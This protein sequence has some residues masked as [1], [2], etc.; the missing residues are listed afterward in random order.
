MKEATAKDV[1]DLISYEG[2]IVGKT[3]LQKIAALLEISGLGAGFSFSYHYYGPYSEDFASAVDRAALLGLIRED[4]RRANWGGRYSVF[5]TNK[6]DHGS[7]PK[8]SLIHLAN[9]ANA[10]VLELTVTAAFLAAERDPDPWS[11]VSSLKPEKA[12]ATNIA[13]AK[14]LYAEF[15]KVETPRKLPAI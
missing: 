5:S 6:V 14:S 9:R 2:E 13:K 7:S 12:S 4:E 8:G 1:A 15:A 11:S 10:I 3:K